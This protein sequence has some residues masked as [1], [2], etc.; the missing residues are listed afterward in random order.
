MRFGRILTATAALA[1]ALVG[2]TTA[3]G[4]PYSPAAQGLPYVPLTA[5]DVSQAPTCQNGELCYTPQLI[6]QAYDFPS[7]RGAPTGAGQTVVV[8]DAYGSPFLG[9]DLAA[10]E[11][12]FG[13]PAAN[14]TEYDQQDVVSD[15]GSGDFLDWG[16]ETSL[17]VEWVH[18]LA[19]NAK[20]VLAVAATDDA[21]NLY[22]VE[23]EVLAQYP[24]AIVAQSFGG[25]EAGPASDPDAENA[26]DQLF[27][28][29]LQ[30][31][32]TI[33]ASSG[34]FGASNLLPFEGLDPAPMASYP[35]SSPFV[36][37]VGGTMGNPYPGGLLAPNGRYGGEQ[38]WN[39]PDFGATGGAPSTIYPRPIWQV[40]FVSSLKRAEPDVSYDAAVNG[41]V[42]IAFG[43]RFGVL[44][45]TSVG[46]PSWAAILAL[47]NEL[48]VKAHRPQL[49]LVTPLLYTLARDRS[50][51]R[52]DFHDVTSG[53]NAL[54]GADA[55]LPGFKAG[56][57][58]DYATG[59][60]TPDVAQLVPDLA[61][62][63]LFGG[64]LFD[65]FIQHGHGRGH[66]RFG[67][68]R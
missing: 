7:G 24:T 14:V 28:Q 54:F 26:F 43:G 62:G 16:L 8:V 32:G 12:Q 41:G 37:S 22:Q 66:G 9:A 10:F 42:I 39:E 45:G 2:A 13:L 52:Q 20:I 11:Q 33:V 57:G 34:D 64:R 36:L 46:A 53:T 40:G 60:G 49:G 19:P 31:G 35:A 3:T 25:D 55:G 4:A 65:F 23:K 51:Y 38:A 27:A 47:A 18:A 58:Y 48:R 50:T 17:D 63:S 5:A 44:G 1:A 61:G 59:L 21:A 56:Y 15:L 29:Q 68:G 30:H 67:P 6:R